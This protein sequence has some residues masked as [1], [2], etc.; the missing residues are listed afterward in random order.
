MNTRKLYFFSLLVCILLLIDGYFLQYVIGL[1]PCALC[2][3]QRVVYY[4]MAFVL[5]IAIYLHPKYRSQ[6]IMAALLSLIALSGA[7]IA[8][9]QAWLQHYPPAGAGC[10]PNLDFMLHNFPLS[11][12]IKTLFYGT[13][14]CAIVTW[15]FI[16]L[17]LAE[18]SFLFFCGFFVVFCKLVIASEARQ[19]SREN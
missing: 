2:I 19:S 10:G 17:S 14:D 6:K 13:G 12:V 18:W 15:R 8:G 3:L 5:L 7:L 9:R 1:K 4:L 16:G 11:E